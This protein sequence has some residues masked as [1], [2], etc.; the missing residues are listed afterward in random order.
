[1]KDRPFAFIEQSISALDHSKIIPTSCDFL[2]N[3]CI[4]AK[5]SVLFCNLYCF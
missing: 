3:D 1:M 4:F 2:L 5:E